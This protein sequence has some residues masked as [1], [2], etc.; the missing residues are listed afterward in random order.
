MKSNGTVERIPSTM[1]TSC[2]APNTTASSI[3]LLF[4]QGVRPPGTWNDGVSAA[5]RALQET[6]AGR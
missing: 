2:F 6:P 5:A 4:Y 1:K 3:G